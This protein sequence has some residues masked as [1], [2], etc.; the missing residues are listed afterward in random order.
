MGY[1]FGFSYFLPSFRRVGGQPQYGMLL[2]LVFFECISLLIQ[3]ATLAIRLMA[4]VGAGHLVLRL[5][6][7]VMVIRSHYIPKVFIISVIIFYAFFELA[8]NFLQAYIVF[9]LLLRYSSLNV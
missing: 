7:R 6:R 9:I 2:G 4:N 3:P 8:V 5:A 1:L